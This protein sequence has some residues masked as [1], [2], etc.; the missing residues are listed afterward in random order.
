[1]AA[2]ANLGALLGDTNSYIHIM[3]RPFVRCKLVRKALI[4]TT[5]VR[6][7]ANVTTASTA[8]GC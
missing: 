2:R 6:R 7:V 1:M 4:D 3:A 8:W 5:V